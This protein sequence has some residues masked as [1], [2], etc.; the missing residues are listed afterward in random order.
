MSDYKPHFVATDAV[1]SKTHV[2][3]TELVAKII[4]GRIAINEI[5]DGD[6]LIRALLRTLLAG[7]VE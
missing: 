1:E 7:L 3:P 5:E 2:V 6:S 4:D